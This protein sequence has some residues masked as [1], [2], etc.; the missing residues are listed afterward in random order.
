MENRYNFMEKYNERNDTENILEYLFY[1]KYYL[2]SI[3]VCFFVAFMFLRYASYKF[4]TSTTIQI[5]DKS[6]DNE[7]ALPTA[8]TIFNRSMVNLE[9]DI[10]VLESFSLHS[11]VVKTLNSN[12]KF[13]DVGLVKTTENHRDEWIKAYNLDFKIELDTV[14]TLNKYIIEKGS[15]ELFIK[16]YDL[17]DNLIEEYVFQKDTYEKSHNLPF[18]LNIDESINNFKK[19]LIIYPFSQ[20]VK[21]FQKLIQISPTSNDSDQLK[22]SMKY[23]NFKVAEDYLNTLSEKFDEDGVKDRK[24]EYR[25]TIDFVDS[26]SIFLKEELQIIEKAKQDFKEKNN[27]S[28]IKSDGILNANQRVSYDSELFKAKSQLDLTIIFEENFFSENFSL[29]PLD[30]GIE[31]ST[32]NQ[33]ILEYNNAIKARDKFLISAGPKNSFVLNLEKQILSFSNNIKVSIKNYKKSLQSTINNIEQKEKEFSDQ[34]SNLPENEKIL[35][36][37][38]RELEIKE[39]LF[40]LLLQ[41]REE[42]SINLAVVKPAIKIIDSARSTDS[43]VYPRSLIVYLIAFSLSIAIPSIII[44][45]ILFFDNKIHIKSQLVDALDEIPIIGEIPHSNDSKRLSSISTSKSRDPITESVRMVLANLNFLLFDKKNKR[46]NVILVT[47]SVK[48]EGKTLISVNTSKL[49]SFKFKKVLLI[50]ADLRNPQIHKFINV[51]K[52]VKGLSNYIYSNNL[53]WKDLIHKNDGLDI[54]LSGAIPPNPTELL[55]SEKFKNLMKEISLHYDYIVIDSAP[56]ILVSDTFEISKYV[57]TT[58]YVVRS[59]FSDKTV[60]NF[61][62]ECKKLKRLENISV[63]LNSVGS[64]KQYSYKYSYRYGYKYGYKYGYNYGYGYGYSEQKD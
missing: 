45:I 61:I 21:E 22:I 39:S 4:E 63:I 35:R 11:N 64:N 1:W 23:V 44:F 9:N 18:E 26:R 50:G 17:K 58:L 20:V 5:I 59:N 19:Q 54:L 24:L 16:H 27:L 28:D 40:L 38:Q 43:P 34:F 41:K 13:F 15:Q 36:S 57:D 32:I 30:I 53:N 6:Q 51:D 25:R 8:M 55:S 47:S 62:N 12:A 56:C 52:S 31:N 42:A 7:M 60:T 29:I 33:A 3:L 46:N 48:G 14:Q 2:V 49:L 10:G 37:I